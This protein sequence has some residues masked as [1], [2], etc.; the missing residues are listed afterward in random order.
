MVRDIGAKFGTFLGALAALD[1]ELVIRTRTAIRTTSSSFSDGAAVLGRPG[2]RSRRARR[3]MMS[4]DISRTGRHIDSPRRGIQRRSGCRR[5]IGGCSG[6]ASGVSPA[7]PPG[8][9]R[10]TVSVRSSFSSLAS[11][12]CTDF[13]THPSWASPVRK[14]TTIWE[15]VSMNKARP[16]P[17]PAMVPS[18]AND[19]R[20]GGLGGGGGGGG[21]GATKGRLTTNRRRRAPRLRKNRPLAGAAQLIERDRP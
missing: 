9:G 16:S 14:R 4:W 7:S 2:F 19:G 5:N 21:G 10:V 20:S 3:G 17:S 13:S 18:S 6:G 1:L 8:S 11:R 15:V 12:P